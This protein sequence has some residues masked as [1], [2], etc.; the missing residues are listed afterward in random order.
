V[1]GICPY[2]VELEDVGRF[3]GMFPAGAGGTQGAPGDDGPCSGI[4]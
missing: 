1:P 3:T 4:C 2:G